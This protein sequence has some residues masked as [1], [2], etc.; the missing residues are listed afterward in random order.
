M[1]AMKYADLPTGAIRV[2]KT[3]VLKDGRSYTETSISYPKCV[4]CGSTNNNDRHWCLKCFN[5][6]D[7]PIRN[8]TCL[9]VDD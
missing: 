3:V 1:P 2:E 8:T 5:D 6:W 4:K 9:I 7:K